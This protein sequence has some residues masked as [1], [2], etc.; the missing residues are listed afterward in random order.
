MV[1]GFIIGLLVLALTTT[2]VNVF[3]DF[4]FKP[5]LSTWVA[6]GGVGLLVG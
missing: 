1:A 4:T 3:N 5:F 2:A 6:F